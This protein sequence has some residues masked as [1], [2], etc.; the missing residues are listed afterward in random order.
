[1]SNSQQWKCRLSMR[2]VIVSCLL[3]SVASPQANFAAETEAPD[4]WSSSAP[5]KEIRPAFSFDAR[6][7][8]SGK[9]C[10]VIE[11]DGREGLI[12]CWTKSFP[13]T[14]GEYYRFSAKRR[15]Q[16]I[17]SPRRGA[18]ARLL[19]RDAQGQPVVRDQ[20]TFASYR[21]GTAPR[22]E[23]EFPRDQAE[24]VAG[25][26]EVADTYRAP[27]R[28][29]QVVVELGFRWAAGGKVE[30]G[31]VTL[32]KTSPPPRRI[33]RLATV[34]FQP[35]EGKTNL[36]KCR[37]FAPLIAKAAETRA[38]LVVLPETLT[39]YASGR[40]YAECAEPIPGPSTEY[41]GQLAKQHDLYI[42]AG[43]HERAGHLVYNVAVL[44]GPDGDVAGKYR[45]VC[46]P[47]SEIEGGTAPGYDYPVFDTRFGRVGMMVCYDG[48]F[49]EVAR[50]LSNRGAEVIAWPVWGC[51]PLLARARA[52]ENHVYLI[53]STYTDASQDWMI[54]AVFGHDGRTL[55][56]AEQWGDVAVVEVDLDRREYWHSLG[57]FKA[58]L[59]RHRPRQPRTD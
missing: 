46:L 9:G 25:W 6:G 55:A 31:D 26:V 2:I 57:D 23:P 36:E 28:A 44:I 39:Y 32:D 42:V 40:P 22:A 16:R 4:G 10:L 13:V 41:F 15:V 34:H 43:L 45:K 54:S 48:F 3:S 8:P 12:G 35:R 50:E 1:M 21:S 33:V 11:S 19:W 20:P 24:A 27:S 14:G 30:W 47:R 37:Q 5:R 38:D 53:S 58:Q 17:D 51:N 7:G 52:C 59:P 56:Q 18:V 49:P 29:E